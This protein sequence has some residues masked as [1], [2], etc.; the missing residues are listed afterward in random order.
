MV[1]IE[2][3]SKTE[4]MY[5]LHANLSA[6]LFSSLEYC[7]RREDAATTLHSCG[8]NKIPQQLKTV[9]LVHS[10]TNNLVQLKII[11]VIIII[12]ISMCFIEYM[13]KI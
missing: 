2:T 7:L 3:I 11:T 13:K 12:I 9:G 10:T 6:I 1:I 4:K 8:A 5:S